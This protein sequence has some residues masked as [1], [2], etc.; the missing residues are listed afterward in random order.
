VDSAGEPVPWYTYPAIEYL[1][2][3]DFSTR[4][5][6]EYGSGNSTLFWSRRAAHVVSVE[7]E[8]GWFEQM[9]PRVPPNC[10]LRHEADLHR[11][12]NVIADYPE[13]FDIIIVEGRRG[14]S[15]G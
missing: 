8:E 13:G 3:F 11:Y 14:G 1:Q 4:S 12:V 10:T 15:A 6:F 9:R 5:V 7:D 2:Q